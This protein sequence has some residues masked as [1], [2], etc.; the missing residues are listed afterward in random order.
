MGRT[1]SGRTFVRN[2]AIQSGDWIDVDLYP[3]FQQPGVRRSRSRPTREVQARIN[4]R[5]AERKLLRLLRANFGQGDQVVHLTYAR[6]M[7]PEDAAA[8][9]KEL[10]NFLRRLKRERKKRGLEELKY[11]SCTEQ[12]KKGGRLHHH[13]VISG[14]M[15]RDEVE[16]LWKKGYAN[17]RRIQWGEDGAAGLAVYLAEFGGRKPTYRRW[18]RSRNLTTP[19]PDYRDGAMSVADLKDLAGEVENGM[20]AAA[21]ELER[22]YPGY[23]VTQVEVSWNGVNLHPYLHFELRRVSGGPRR[24]AG[25]AAPS[26]RG[27]RGGRAGPYD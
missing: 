22:R 16:K 7:E 18:N 5:D 9:Q 13:A 12:G 17:A 6:G 15:S 14:G 1:Y 24:A 2:R 8:A 3:V 27:R 26:G 11:L 20:P 21:E 23:E 25:S 10:Y 4:Q 19:E